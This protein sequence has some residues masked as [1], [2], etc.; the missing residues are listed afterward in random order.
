MAVFS[1]L[2]QD[3]GEFFIHYSEEIISALTSSSTNPVQDSCKG[4]FY[5]SFAELS[6]MLQR[7]MGTTSLL[8][9]ILES[10]EKIV[11]HT[12]KSLS[13]TITDEET[14]VAIYCLEE[15]IAWLPWY[16]FELYQD[17]S[18]VDKTSLAKTQ[19]KVLFL[20]PIVLHT[21]HSTSLTTSLIKVHGACCCLDE[22]LNDQLF[23][24]TL[25]DSHT[26][27]SEIAVIL[28]KVNMSIKNDLGEWCVAAQQS[29]HVVLERIGL[30]ICDPATTH[31][32]NDLYTNPFSV[33]HA[34]SS[35]SSPL[36]EHI[37]SL[38]S[39]PS[40]KTNQ[41]ITQSKA[42]VETEVENKSDLIPPPPNQLSGSMKLKIS[43]QRFNGEE[44]QEEKDLKPA[45]KSK[46]NLEKLNL[47]SLPS[48]ACSKKAPIL[49]QHDKSIEQ[50]RYYVDKVQSITLKH[51]TSTEESTLLGSFSD[52]DSEDDVI[53][54]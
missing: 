10:I 52:L 28:E 40:E 18:S 41:D 17:E 30:N 45:V 49:N 36:R 9:C 44:W 33:M 37:M 51:Q 8:Y 39:T 32:N 11:F 42:S 27:D 12:E 43:F 23:I 38:P 24:S 5:N 35:F 22:S 7:Q 31:T 29:L 20:L 48:L 26:R 2:H 34:Q 50:D 15:V 54:L 53:L 46:S 16:S 4:D 13:E 1:K 21:F 6:L 19:E 3:F 25:I 14:V 47:G